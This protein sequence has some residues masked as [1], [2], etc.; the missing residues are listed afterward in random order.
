MI[1]S[2]QLDQWAM[3]I[4]LFNLFK[5]DRL[6][7]LTKKS[8]MWTLYANLD[9]TMYILCSS[10]GLQQQWY[11]Q[12]A[13]IQLISGQSNKLHGEQKFWQDTSRTKILSAVPHI[14]W[15]LRACSA[16]KENDRPHLKDTWILFKRQLLQLKRHMQLSPKDNRGIHCIVLLKKAL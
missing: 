4:F 5:A 9:C 15:L 8:T 12:K 10:Q 7:L 16:I 11:L 14:Q 13:D 6:S 3:H 1:I 2:Q